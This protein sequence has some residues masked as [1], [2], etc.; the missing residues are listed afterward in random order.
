MEHDSMGIRYTA[1]FRPSEIAALQNVEE[2]KNEP[3]SLSG[4]NDYFMFWVRIQ[5]EIP[6]SSRIRK[7]KTKNIKFPFSLQQD[8]QL[9]LDKDTLPCTLFVPITETRSISG[10][11]L[12]QIGFRKS[13]DRHKSIYG[14]SLVYNDQLYGT[15]PQKFICEDKIFASLPN[16]KY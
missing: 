4:L 9:I 6:N 5:P 15:G 12:F 1:Q 11:L 14:A 2:G 16:L 10:Q 8:F 13:T 3:I 7:E